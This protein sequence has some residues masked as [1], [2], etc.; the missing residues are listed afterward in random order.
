[1]RKRPSDWTIGEDMSD[2]K[3]KFSNAPSVLDLCGLGLPKFPFPEPDSSRRL[4]RREEAELR[5]ALAT[6]L[7]QR[8]MTTAKEAKVMGG[9]ID[10]AALH[11]RKPVAIIETKITEPMK[12]IGQLFGYRFGVKGTPTMVLALPLRSELLTDL[13]INACQE[14]DV[15]LWAIEKN[16]TPIRLIR[17]QAPAYPEGLVVRR[18][19]NWQS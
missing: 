2:W 3:D 15:E 12:G 11:N 13:L 17:S 7:D 4:N 10:I 9:Y 19:L 1:M 16:G 5:D 6:Y 8:G 18:D 14:A